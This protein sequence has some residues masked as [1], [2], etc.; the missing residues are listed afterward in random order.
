[1]LTKNGMEIYV[2][3][4]WYGVNQIWV[5]SSLALA[6][7]ALA[8]LALLVARGVNYDE[9]CAGYHSNI[10]KQT[11]ETCAIISQFMLCDAETKS[12]HFCIYVIR[13]RGD[14]YMRGERRTSRT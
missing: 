10:I 12:T 3:Y 5:H 1:M 13:G 11:N 8:T 9:A 6:T 7:L 14:G 2:Y 4:R